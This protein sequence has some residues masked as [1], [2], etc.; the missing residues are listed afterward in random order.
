MRFDDSWDRDQFNLHYLTRAEVI[1]DFIAFFMY[2]SCGVVNVVYDH[3][4]EPLVKGTLSMVN[5]IC[6]LLDALVCNPCQY[7]WGHEL[8]AADYEQRLN[9][10]R[11]FYHLA[12]YYH[13]P[14]RM[15][16]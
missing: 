11:A 2:V 12:T 4:P 8:A 13:A 7:R 14:T 10:R 1:F 15:N 16:I 5:G 3:R 6:F 9:E